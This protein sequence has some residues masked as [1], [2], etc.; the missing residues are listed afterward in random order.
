VLADHHH[1]V[2]VVLDLMDSAEPAGTLSALVG[3][4]NAYSIVLFP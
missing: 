1:A 2:A 3:S 4:E